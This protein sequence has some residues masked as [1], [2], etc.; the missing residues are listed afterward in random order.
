VS[1][2]VVLYRQSS[3]GVALAAA[4]PADLLSAASIDISQVDRFTVFLKN[5]GSNA[6]TGTTITYTIGTLTV[7]DTTSIGSINAGATKSFSLAPGSTDPAYQR[8]GISGTSTSGTTVAVE[9][10]AVRNS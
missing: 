10:V 1:N 6:L 7:T 8:I 9:A 3:A 5:T 4:T 2:R